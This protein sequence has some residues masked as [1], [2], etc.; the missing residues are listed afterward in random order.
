[1]WMCTT[2]LDKMPAAQGVS[3]RRKN[4]DVFYLPH[5]GAKRRE[6]ESFPFIV[7]NGIPNCEYPGK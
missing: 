1:M 6:T 2:C 3:L 7:R 4:G 5:P